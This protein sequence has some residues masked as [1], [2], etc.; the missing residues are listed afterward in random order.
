MRNHHGMRKKNRR[1]S[2][3]F[4]NSNL[5][6]S[7][8][9]TAVSSLLLCLSLALLFDS[10]ASFSLTSSTSS[11]PSNNNNMKMSS[12]QLQQQH[13]YPR[14]L[15][16]GGFSLPPLVEDRLQIA[17]SKNSADDNDDDDILQ[18]NILLIKPPD[19]ESLWEWYAYTKRQSDSDP[20]WGRVWP[21]A[22]SLARLVLRSL[23]YNNDID[24][25][26]QSLKEPKDEDEETEE[27]EWMERAVT[28]LRTASHVVEVGCGLGVAGLAYASSSSSSSLAATTA[29]SVSSG[30]SSTNEINENEN[31][32]RRTIT[33]LDRE[34]Y[35]LHCVMA[36]AST[37]GLA[38]GPLLPPVEG[39]GGAETNIGD[40]DLI[41]LVT[42]RAAIDD[43]T[44]PTTRDND[45]DNNDN[46]PVKN[47]CYRDLHLSTLSPNH[48]DNSNTLLLASDILYEPS[49]TA[50]LAQ[51]LQSLLHP[52]NGGYALIADPIKER[53]L[54]CRE[55][56]VE[57]VKGLGGEVGILPMPELDSSS[58]S[59]SSSSRAMHN[60]G[61]L[62][63]DSDVDIDGSLCRSMLIVV[64]FRGN[65]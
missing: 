13:E 50:S 36:S 7:F 15:H 47:I 63:L 64:H 57:S 21:T 19:M 51:K 27:E 35:A 32:R 55:S 53:T 41:P 1:K 44:L 16:P 23:D 39:S 56:F 58:S 37:N 18:T 40:G 10:V 48:Y 46:S 12:Q 14:P 60:R 29:A 31:K 43:W 24:T 45:D 22:L 6:Q 11:S 42:A 54:G 26:Y 17:T 3:S 61:M 49:S 65:E 5:H 25:S 59:S 52:T 30:T 2:S 33:F 28:A 20:S 38:T 8:F 9:F 4:K 34:P 62:L